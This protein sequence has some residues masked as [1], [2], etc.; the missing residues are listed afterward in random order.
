MAKKTQRRAARHERDQ[1]GCMW[2]FISMFNFRHGRYAHK[3][4]VDRRHGSKRVTASG[5]PRNHKLDK[6]ECHN[7]TSRETLVGEER[8][9]TIAV[10]KPSVKKLIEQELFNEKETKKEVDNSEEGRVSDSEL[11]GRRRKDQ[12]RKIKTRGKSCDNFGHINVIDNAEPDVHHSNQK[13]HRSIRSLDIDNM[14]EEFCCEIHRRS[15]SHVKN[16]KLN[17]NPE[18]YKERL[19]E[20]VKFLISQKLLLGNGLREDSKILTSKDLMEVFQILGSDEEL[21]LKLLQDPDLLVPRDV[22]DL[23]NCQSEKEEGNPTLFEKSN[24]SEQS[25][26]S[27]SK[28]QFSFFRGKNR[29]EKFDLNKC[30]SSDRIIILKPG[31]ASLLNPEMGNSHTSSPESYPMRNKAQNERISSHFFLSEIKRKLKHTIRKEQQGSPRD[32][33]EFRKSVPTKDH[34]FI[35]RMTRPSITEKKS[36]KGLQ[37]HE[38]D[39]KKQRMSNI[40]IEA[41]KHLSEMLNNGDFDLNSTSKQVQRTLGRILSL[42]EYSSPLGSPGRR[43]PQSSSTAHRRSASADFPSLEG[44]KRESHESPPG[45]AMENADLQLC[46]FNSNPESCIGS[47]QPAPSELTEES[48]VKE[49]GIHIKDKISSDDVIFV[50]EIEI[51]PEEADTNLGA[52]SDQS[53]PSMDRSNQIVDD[54]STVEDHDDQREGGNSKQASLE[55]SQRPGSSSVDSPSSSVAKIEEPK[56]CTLDL[57]EWS[58]PVSVLDPMFVEDD[59]SPA[60]MRSLSGKALV[61][62]LYIQFEEND[63]PAGNQENCVETVKDDKDLVSKY[64]EAVLDAVDTD[65][66]ELYLKSQYSDQLLEPV[67]ISNVPFCPTELCSDHE[68]LFDC[69]NDVL[70]DFCSCPPWVSFSK[71]RTQVFSSVKS[72]VHEVQEVVYWN[73]LPLPLHSALDQIVRKD[74]AKAGNWLDIRGGIDCIGAETGEL[75]LQELLEEFVLDWYC[76]DTDDSSVPAE[77]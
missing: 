36:P 48:V 72:I 2:G 77:L 30:E 68:L 27:A 71:P 60:R 13:H 12:K 51:T 66:E 17:Q 61:Q 47:L 21:L 46:H 44:N 64:V 45:H 15:T 18:D 31:P 8:N 50:K 74:M 53:N 57:P 28:K 4:L 75:V 42:P 55:E 25:S 37:K 40:Y 62:P 24:A 11:E 73:L 35:E 76:M 26:L 39:D 67:L 20:L 52:L 14:I 10:I 32:G 43:R 3:L 69:I 65:W 56:S 7:E 63:S 34:F 49:D 59:I 23:Q 54:T 5:N 38:D 19:R 33:E 70:L 6:P 22:Q 9:V 16:K 29:R 1:L 58:S 41:K